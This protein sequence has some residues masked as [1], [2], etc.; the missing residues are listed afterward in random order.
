[1][2]LVPRA[3]FVHSAHVALAGRV[4]VVRGADGEVR[5]G[6]SDPGSVGDCAVHQAA[7]LAAKVERG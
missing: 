6:E 2:G 4:D 7:E 1:M 5:L 3:A